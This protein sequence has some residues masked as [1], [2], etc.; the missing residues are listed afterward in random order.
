MRRNE[1]YT[2]EAQDIARRFYSALQQSGILPKDYLDSLQDKLD[3]N[4]YSLLQSPKP[5]IMVY[6][7]YNSGKSTLVNALCGEA[8]AEVADR[9]MT[10]RI[11]EYDAGKYTLIDSPGVDAP[12]DHEEIADYQLDECHIILFVI[13]SKGIF[14]SRAN[15]EKMRLLIGKGIPFYIILNDRGAALP[16]DPARRAQAERKHNGELNQIK[17]KIIHNLSKVSGDARIGEKYEVIVLNAKRAWAGVEQKKP[18]LV[19]KSNIS[20]LRSRID[21]ILMDTGAMEWL[22]APISTLDACI[23]GAE[24][25][26]YKQLGSDDYA[27]ERAVLQ[28]KMAGMRD[29]VARQLQSVVYARREEM[30]SLQLHSSQA[31]FGQVA[32]DISQEVQAVYKREAGSLMQYIKAKF[33][34]LNLH[35]EDGI[36]ISY[37][38]PEAPAST[39]PASGMP[40]AGIAD[41]VTDGPKMSSAVKP[42]IGGTVAAKALSNVVPAPVPGGIVLVSMIKGL[43]DYVKNSAKKEEAEFRQLLKQA[44]ANNRAAEN[45]AAEQMRIRQDARTVANIYLDRLAREFRNALYS[46]IDKQN[47]GIIQSLDAAV[48]EQHQHNQKIRQ[49]L[50]SLR[51][52]RNEISMLRQKGI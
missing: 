49:L 11:G 31:D 6:G 44:E 7:I 33:P 21:Q 5:K 8:V 25:Q 48:L 3:R 23:A 16:D 42:L 34:G 35:V 26:L 2:S 36:N 45:W 50:D 9:P 38:P 14:E 51:G 4:F 32:E 20:A 24:S 17:R 1:K 18:A 10:Y 47:N 13:S 22:Q 12:M 43:L 19:E 30:Y 40:E 37:T 15:Y 39:A 41:P 27:G 28:L 52:F 46:A 29:E